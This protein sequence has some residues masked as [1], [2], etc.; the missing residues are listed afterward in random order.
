MYGNGAPGLPG[1]LSGSFDKGEITYNIF[2]TIL[3]N[4]VQQSPEGC[5]VLSATTKLT[6]EAEAAAYE[7]YHK[8]SV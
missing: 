5:K 7:R 2:R 4:K 1:S 8:K 6:P 3:C